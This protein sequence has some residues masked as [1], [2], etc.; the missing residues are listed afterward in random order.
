[1]MIVKLTRN[2]LVSAASLLLLAGGAVYPV[3]CGMGS[4]CCMPEITEELS[5]QQGHCGCGC[6][7]FEESRVPDQNALTIAVLDTK[8]VQ[9]E[10]DYI[11]ETDNSL[12]E[13]LDYRF[14]EREKTSH[15]PPLILDNRYT[16]LLC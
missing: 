15:S 3:E 9:T 14:S 10:F 8:P 11:V 6:G 2:V 5:L 7:S 13:D 12:F 4:C 16:P 1:M